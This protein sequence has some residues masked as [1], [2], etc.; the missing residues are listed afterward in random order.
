[1]AG[2]IMEIIRQAIEESGKTRYRIH[3]DT[4][5]DQAVL[6]KIAGGGTCSMETADRLCEYLGLE[7]KPRRRKAS[8]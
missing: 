8:R 3:K 7:L 6:C 5:V 4:G 2:M 1:M